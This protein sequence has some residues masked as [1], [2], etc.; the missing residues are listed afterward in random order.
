VK[1]A[2]YNRH[3]NP[4]VYTETLG[5]ADLSS[6]TLNFKQLSRDLNAHTLP[7]FSWIAPNIWHDGHTALL[8]AADSYAS[9]LVPRVLN[10]LGPHGVLYLTWDEGQKTDQRGAHGLGGGHV[11]LIALGPG[12]QA[13]ARVHT[14]ANHY[15]LLKTIETTLRLRPLGHA[16]ASATPVLS[17]L[18]RG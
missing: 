12:A 8:S 14:L 15:A 17:G 16:A 6:D 5:A 18:L 1:G 2:P 4:F 9:R 3:Y 13:G 10:A 11:P 7:R